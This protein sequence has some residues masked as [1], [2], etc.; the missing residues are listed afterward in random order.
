[1]KDKIIVW[2]DSNLMQYCACYYLQKE[3][4]ADFYAIVDVTNKT[5]HFFENQTLVNFKKIWFFHDNTLPIKHPNFEYLSSFEKKYNIDLWKL[6]VNDRIFYNFN[7]FYNFSKNE[8]LSILENECNFL[9]SVLNE[10]NPDF[11]IMHE[12]YQHHD[13]IFFE[14]SKSKNIKVM[15]FYFS[16]FGYNC[17]ISENIHYADNISN[18]EQI[19]KYRSFSELAKHYESL[20]VSDRIKKQNVNP[21]GNK[22]N[23]ASA[24][25][26]YLFKTKNDNTKTHYSYFGHSKIRATTNALS[27]SMKTKSR[28][29]FIE[30]NLVKDVDLNQKFV[31]Y[32]LHIEQERSTLIVT[33][34]YTND[35]EFIKNIVKSL[36]IDYT[37]Y[38]KE[39]PSQL[40]RHWRDEK[41]YNEL[42]NI[43]NVILI[44]P[45]A[46][47]LDLVKNCS[48]AITKSGTVALEAAFYE[49]PA[50]TCADFDYTILPSIERLQSV[51]DLPKLIRNC[52]EKK[53]NSKSLDEYITFKEKNT[54]PFD[55]TKFEI[56]SVKKF[57][58][59][60]RLADVDIT[61][62]KM[63]EFLKENEENLKILVDAFVKKVYYFKNSK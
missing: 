10:I 55:G 14:L 60:G 7:D 40:T 56:N 27:G 45:H 29:N 38:V 15:A 36:P 1:M 18:I 49:K 37:L 22:S 11:V 44:H 21:F 8:I 6:A 62:E 53:F 20:K 41:I 59:G 54:F 13:E 35:I 25:F 51:E 46:S 2:L 58:H 16:T 52:L 19:T 43:P 30:K 24:A 5:R 28:W 42:L 47:S 39:H 48:L 3:I 33:P 17:E 34:F 4:D 61:N 50:I 12:P 63:S 31:Y 9:E 32:P 23:I 57:F 26:D